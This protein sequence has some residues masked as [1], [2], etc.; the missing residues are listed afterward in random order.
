MRASEAALE[1]F[2]QLHFLQPS[3]DYPNK[4]SAKS[5]SR[6]AKKYCGI[7]Q[8]YQSCEVEESGRGCSFSK[9]PHM[10]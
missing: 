3:T 9:L 4:S 6:G 10:Y 7:K 5:N 1:I 2:Q 8:S